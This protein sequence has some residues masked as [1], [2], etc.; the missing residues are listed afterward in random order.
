ML[1]SYVKINNSWIDSK[2]FN[3]NLLEIISNSYLICVGIQGF[4]FWV[5]WKIFFGHNWCL[6]LYKKI[7]KTLITSWINLK[8]KLE[9]LHNSSH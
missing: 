4:E 2:Y 1:E 7:I 9:L 6:D 5:D 3:K 8:K